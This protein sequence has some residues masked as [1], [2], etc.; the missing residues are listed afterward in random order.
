MEMEIEEQGE[1]GKKV[2]CQLTD[3]EGNHLGPPMYLPQNAAPKELQQIVNKLLSNV[4][5]HQFGL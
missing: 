1:T 3:P 5:F 2:M 4:S